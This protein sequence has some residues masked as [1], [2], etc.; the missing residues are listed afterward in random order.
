MEYFEYK[1][2]NALTGKITRGVMT[3]DDLEA[4]ADTLKRRGENILEINRLK[5]FMNLRKLSFNLSTHVSKKMTAEFY[6]MLSFML[7]AG[8]SLHESLISIRDSSTNKKLRRLSSV[9]A[10]EVRK[11]TTLSGAMKKSGLFPHASTEQIKAGEESGTVTTALKRLIAQTE[12]E[13]DFTS[14]LKNAMIYPV[15]ISVVMVLVLWVL[16]TVV[17]PSLS[18]T[19]IEMGGELPLITKIVI[20]TSNFISDA[21][22]YLIVLIIAGILAYR[23]AIKNNGIKYIID[24]YKLKIPIVGN[25][26]EKIEL[27]RFCRN[28]AAMQTSGITLAT[29]LKIVEAAIKNSKIAGAIKKACKLI[30]ISGMNLGT[31]L[32]RSGSF[33]SMMLQLIEVGISSGQIC[34]VLDKIASQYE[35]EVDASLK[36]VTSLIEPIMIVIVGLLAGTVVVAIFIPMFAIADQF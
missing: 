18:E 31:A 11:G 10:D 4:A 32:T 26:L 17:V 2:K 3:A 34:D 1:V 6:T 13:L 9:T 28:L 22:P 29:S 24:T 7:E 20:G 27:S 33:P 16:M 19:L 23:M 8:M 30:E 36:R 15:I 21:T 5:D 14:K 12:K 35:K 25:M